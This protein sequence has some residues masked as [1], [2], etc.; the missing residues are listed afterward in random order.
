MQQY[1]RSRPEGM[2]LVLPGGLLSPRTKQ[3]PPR[4]QAPTN[5]AD[6]TTNQQASH[7]VGLRITFANDK[8][9]VDDRYSQCGSPRSQALLQRAISL[10]EH[11]E[12][13]RGSNAESPTPWN[14]A[15]QDHVSWTPCSPTLSRAL[16]LSGQSSSRPR[17]PLVRQRSPQQ[18]TRAVRSDAEIARAVARTRRNKT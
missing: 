12:H 3:T 1:R 14:R 16:A 8:G 18:R 10:R 13:A 15:G 17:S 4:V 11:R 7:S 9:G 5:P 2:P 6:T